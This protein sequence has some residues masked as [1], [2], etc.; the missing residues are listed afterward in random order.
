M[1]S[2][3]YFPSLLATKPESVSW[4]KMMEVLRG[5][6]LSGITSQY[7]ALRS[8]LDRTEASGDKNAAD[9][10]K[11]EMKKVKMGIPAIV[12]QAHLEGGKDK[13]CIRS[14]TGYM[15]ADFRSEEH[16]SE[17]QSQR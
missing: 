10:L 14:Y 5:D 16:T 8:Q 11:A 13:S 6:F 9:S 1:K 3:S 2:I 17:L 7:R 15:M 4:E 12:C